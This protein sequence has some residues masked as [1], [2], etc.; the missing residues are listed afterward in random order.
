MS[1]AANRCRPPGLGA[2]LR[3]VALLLASL[4]CAP[5]DPG[6]LPRVVSAAPTGTVPPDAVA[7]EIVLSAPLDG[8]GIEDGRFFALCRR[9]DLHDV[10]TQAE[11]EG[12]LGGS[13]PVVPARRAL[14][15]G[16]TRAVLTPAAPLEPGR[17]WAAVLSRRVRS[18]DGRPVLDAE[19]H[20]RTF[21]LL[22]ETGAPADATAPQGRWVLPPHGPA[23]SNVVALRVSFDEPVS[24]EL[25]L[26]PGAPAASAVAPGPDVLGLDLLGPLSPGP[27]PIDLRGVHDAAGNAAASIASLEVSA[28]PS[29]AAP[30]I[31]D[32]RT[33]PGELSVRLQA[34]LADMG[35]LVAE[36]SADPGDPACGIAPESP[37]TTTWIGEVAACP[38][39]DPCAPAA[40]ACPASL[41]LR[42]LCP[43]RRVRVRLASED[44]AGHRGAPGA[45]TEI[46]SL[47]PRPV[48][49]LT[50]VLADADSPEAGGEYAE[51]A[52]VGTGDADLA[53][54]T[55]AKRSASGS[56]TR[57]QLA[58]LAGGPVS[59]GGHALVVGAA[60]DGRYPLASGT[61]VYRCGATALAG[62]IANDRPVALAL[63][64]P[65]GQVVSTA[66]IA[67][68]A[69]RCTQG[70]LERIHPGGPDAASNF[71]CPGV[72]TPGVCNRSTPPEECPRRP[73]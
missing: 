39:W 3:R 42:G 38:G 5:Q 8:A 11:S 12:G 57:C 62:G 64:D 27:L 51:V 40:A 4:G 66:G 1:R 19:G 37:A 59:P 32:V 53:G 13:A 29:T 69:P 10:A 24:G 22:F 15:A 50:E 73:W 70:S 21:A 55:L 25:A 61:A 54:Y 36:L 28:C 71:A 2:R 26:G 34:T 17:R 56:Y 20:S 52:N 67:E 23:P 60:Y 7:V 41:D 9:E 31:A 49:V 48:P 18:A 6:P 72:K 47:P 35:R 43:G 44:L 45:W 65:L 30:G 68:P 46:A 58:S 14:T 16:G 33:A 63:E